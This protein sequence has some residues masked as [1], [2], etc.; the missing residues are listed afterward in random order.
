M[1]FVFNIFCL[2]PLCESN[3]ERM[4]EYKRKGE[5]SSE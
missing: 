4:E 3:I 2:N 1:I 5:D